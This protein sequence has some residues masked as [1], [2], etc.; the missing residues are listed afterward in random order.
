MKKPLFTAVAALALLPLSACG[1]SSNENAEV[2]DTRG[3]DPMASQLANRAP[4]ELPPSVKANSTFRC[5]DNSLVYV[6]FYSGD[7]L[8]DIRT[9]KGGKP[10]RLTAPEAG[11]PFAAD[12]YVVDGSAKTAT[13]T[14]PG[15]SAQSC[16]A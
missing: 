3:P 4:I 16:K 10:T 11:K 12:G 2:I 6:D 15:K 1:S 7:K 9:E 8:A 14:V 13:I 5:K